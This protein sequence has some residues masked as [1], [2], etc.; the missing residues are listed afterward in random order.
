VHQELL[1]TS[2]GNHIT[3]MLQLD[4]IGKDM[5]VAIAGIG[6][7][8]PAENGSHNRQ[9]FL[10]VNDGRISCHHVVVKEV[11]RTETVYVSDKQAHF[12]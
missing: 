7:F 2:V 9:R 3:N 5:L 6:T 4:G 11:V 8:F 1:R 12:S 10:L